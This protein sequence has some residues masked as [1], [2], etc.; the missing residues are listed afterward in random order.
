MPTQKDFKRLVRS[1]MRKTGESYTAARR[2]ILDK[3]NPAPQPEYAGLA[4]MSDASVH[5]RTGRTWAEWVAVLDSVQ[6]A[7]KPHRAIA[8][9]VSSHGAP[10]WWSQMVTVGYE[11]IRGLREKGQRRD[12]G[13]EASRSRTYNV[14]I[15]T[16]FDAFLSA[17]KRSRWLPV[18]V[19]VRSSA[20]HKRMRIEWDD[21]TVVQVAFLNKGKSKSTV[22]V[23][24]QKLRDK[25]AATAMK[26]VWAEH[27]DKLGQML[28]G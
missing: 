22:A 24:H 20:L 14:P 7:D 11:R 27:F 21:K 26:T 1:R 5:K 17:R 6:A 13:Y 4:G 12:G 28:G 19:A 25:S 23:Q 15:A 9:I 18:R 10:E 3:N 8:A 2:Q 16:L